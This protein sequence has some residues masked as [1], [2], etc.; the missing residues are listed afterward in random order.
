VVLVL[1]AALLSLSRGGV[2]AFLLS[3]VVAVVVCGRAA[4]VRGR[5]LLAAAL[6]GAV[7]IGAL[8][9]FGFEA[10]SNRFSD[11]TSGSLERLDRGAG[12]RTVWAAVAAAIP[13]FAAFGSGVGSH[14][15][16]CPVYLKNPTD[17]VVFTHAESGPL[18]VTLETGAIG[19]ALVACGVGFCVVWCLGGLRG[20]ASSR[21]RACLGAICAAL[22]ANLAHTWVDFVWYVP[23]CTA[24]VA[25]LAGLA[26]RSWQLARPPERQV[27]AWRLSPAAAAVVG[28]AVATLSIGMIG[29]RFR[30]SVA[31]CYWDRSRVLVQKIAG[32]EAN[33]PGANADATEALPRA[34]EEEEL[35]LADLQKAVDWYPEDARLHLSMARSHLRLFDLRQ[36][37]AINPMPLTQV[38]DAVIASQ[39]QFASR[40]ALDDWLRRAFGRH[41]EH[42][43]GALHH[44]RYAL[45][46]CPLLGEG[47]LYLSELC[48]LD[49]AKPDSKWAYLNQAMLVRPFDGD[50]WSM[51]SRETLQ[52]LLDNDLE[53]WVRFARGVL[54]SGSARQKQELLEGPLRCVPP[55]GLPSA[56]EFLVKT[57]EPDFESLSIM[58]RAGQKCDRPE[59]L[60]AFLGY[61]AQVAEY[62]ARKSK[63]WVA[64]E[65]WAVAATLYDKLGDRGRA[66]EC[67]QGAVTAN[68]SDLKARYELACLLLESGASDKAREHLE[69]CLRRSPENAM[70]RTKH[71]EALRA[72]LDQQGQTAARSNC[73]AR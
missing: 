72:S 16:V 50:V 8:N 29:N 49:G 38:R 68:S 14:Q 64:A 51:A 42:L 11:L 9:L 60:K 27:R 52:A 44:T 69:L 48:F 6:A 22:A 36:T 45:A 25:I 10:I 5:F 21:Q 32:R 61:Y 34:M 47:Y 2:T 58:Y 67:A 19:A 7:V 20:A 62:E 4:A 37:A 70:F 30:A 41:C 18:Q 28:V 3:G 31:Q 73:A 17:G 23:A 15:E 59:Q 1:V 13:D 54:R 39:D 55:E 26:C 40:E 65:R 63:G 56:L 71:R 33:Q 66:V 12:R 57:L 24:L 35:I 43:E 53:P 46:D